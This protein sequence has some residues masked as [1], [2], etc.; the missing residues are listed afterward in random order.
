MCCGQL[1]RFTAP[2]PHGTFRYAT[3]EVEVDGSTLPARTQVLVCLAA[4]NRDPGAFPE[5]DRLDLDRDT[6]GHLAFGHGI[7]HCLGAPLARLE[8]R[9]ALGRLL[10]RFCELE[11]AIARD[12]LHWDHGDGLVLRGLSALPVRVTAC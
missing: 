11:L 6:T 7:H 2:V 5:P 4:A 10:E 9:I 3:D 8:A 12:Q 1:L